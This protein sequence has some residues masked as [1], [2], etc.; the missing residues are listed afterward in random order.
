MPSALRLRTRTAVAVA[1]L[2]VVAIAVAVVVTR[3]N[4]GPAPGPS[5]ATQLR[6]AKSDLERGNLHEA[7]KG[8]AVVLEREPDHPD[9]L[10]IGESSAAEW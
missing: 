9:A 5:I 7:R 2:F 6:R 10:S 4:G 8:L 3:Q 1:V